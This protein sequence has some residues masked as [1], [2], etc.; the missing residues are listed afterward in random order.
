MKITTSCGSTWRGNYAV[1][2]RAYNQGV[3]YRIETSLPQ[4][5]V[6]IYGEEVNINFAG[7]YSVYY[8][9]EDSFFSH[10][11]RKFLYLSLKDIAA[12]AMASCA[13]GEWTQGTGSGLA[14]AEA[15]VDDYPGLWLRGNNSNSL[16]GIF[17][18]YPLKE[19]LNRDRDYKVTQAADY[20]ARHQRD[21][22]LSLARN[23]DCRKRWRLDRESAGLSAG[24]VRRRCRTRRGSNPA[25]VAWDWW[26]ANN[27]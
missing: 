14:I 17:P 19:E 27:I 6:K 3:A 4:S 20:I 8:P 11:E 10:N 21:A 13:R 1:V 24:D 18:P 15:D 23:R 16:S 9:Q 26:N 2:F 22:H 25:K 5:E 7:D 12:G